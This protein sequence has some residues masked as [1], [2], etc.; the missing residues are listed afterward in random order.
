MPAI[1]P[2]RVRLEHDGPLAVI[3]LCFPPLNLFDGPM[4]DSVE[5]AVAAV[6]A[7]PPRALLVRAE[8]RAV[9]GGVDVGNVFDGMSPADGAA[10]W[11]RL[12]R[13]I[14]AVEALPFPTVFAAHAL[15]LTA[16]FELSLGCDLLLAAES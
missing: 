4:I 7:D 11:E 1:R 12:L 16:A 13:M 9:S 14:H 3:T 5:A 15:T 2:D 10:L 6:E 8:G